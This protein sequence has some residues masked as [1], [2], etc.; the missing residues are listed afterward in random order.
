MP[1]P[2]RERHDAYLG[3]YLETGEKRI[4]GIGRIVFAQ[5]KDGTNFPMELSIGE[6]ASGNDRLFTGFIRDLTERRETEERL[7]SLRS[8]LIHVARVSAM[9]TMASTLDRKS[10]R[11]NSSH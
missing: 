10:T 7:E 4:I 5:R 2:D 11:L 3:R 1:S 9:G 8:E 6:A